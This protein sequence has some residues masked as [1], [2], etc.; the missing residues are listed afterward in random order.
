[1][2]IAQQWQCPFK[3]GALC[4]NKVS[5]TP[6]IAHAYTERSHCMYE[7]TFVRTHQTHSMPTAA[8]LEL[9][10]PPPP[11]PTNKMEDTSL[12]ALSLSRSK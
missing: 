11:R 6:Y 12:L 1:M 7:C 3:E 5:L 8:T 2:D 10:P 4:S 9:N